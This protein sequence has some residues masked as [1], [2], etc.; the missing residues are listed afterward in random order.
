MLFGVS[1]ASCCCDLKMW[2]KADL[3]DK[4]S[5]NKALWKKMNDWVQPEWD[6]RWKL[7]PAER[8]NEACDCRVWPFAREFVQ[9]CVSSM[10]PLESLCYSN[11]FPIKLRLITASRWP[12]RQ[13]AQTLTNGPR[14][15]I[16]AAHSN[17]L[18]PIRV[19]V[20]MIREARRWR[21]ENIWK[22]PLGRLLMLNVTFFPFF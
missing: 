20:N 12:R 15:K 1:A 4:V 9:L 7:T 13:L 10:T 5:L 18:L 14:L 16:L 3:V 2:K 22:R 19:Q 6:K 21:K 11:N 17:C 8:R